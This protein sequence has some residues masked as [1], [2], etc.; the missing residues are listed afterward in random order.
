MKEGKRRHFFESEVLGQK[1]AK[2]TKPWC[3]EKQRYLPMFGTYWKL[4]HAWKQRLLPSIDLPTSQ[5]PL[6]RAEKHHWHSAK[7]VPSLLQK[8]LVEHDNHPRR[9]R[10]ILRELV[11]TVIFSGTT[12]CSYVFFFPFYI[13]NLYSL[14]QSF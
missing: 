4:F 1:A 10:A 5:G 7:F 3:L 14:L 13:C 11:P 6:G 12:Q 2:I 8:D 9:W